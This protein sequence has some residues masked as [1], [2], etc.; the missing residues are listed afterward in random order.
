MSDDDPVSPLAEALANDIGSGQR[1]EKNVQDGT[2]DADDTRSFE[3]VKTE[4]CE[5]PDTDPRV[6]TTQHGEYE[7]LHI[8]GSDARKHTTGTIDGYGFSLRVDGDAPAGLV[9]DIES[10]LADVK[11][12]RENDG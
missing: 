2:N 4:V 9:A 10:A 6:E 5:T 11:A 12:E 1:H 3:D 7:A 8:G